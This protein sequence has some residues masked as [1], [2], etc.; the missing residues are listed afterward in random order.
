MKSSYTFVASPA[1]TD[2]QRIC[3]ENHQARFLVVKS[4]GVPALTFVRVYGLEYCELRR[5]GSRPSGR[6]DVPPKEPGEGRNGQT[7]VIFEG[8]YSKELAPKV[9]TTVEVY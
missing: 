4:E 5:I 6:I 9:R 7:W 3:R 2:Y 8:D 1:D